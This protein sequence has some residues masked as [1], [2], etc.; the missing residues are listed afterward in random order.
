MATNLLVLDVKLI[1]K[2]AVSAS[3]FD[4]MLRSE[5]HLLFK[6]TPAQPKQGLRDVNSVGAWLRTTGR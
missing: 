2:G 6:A 4:N 1:C 3:D 5:G